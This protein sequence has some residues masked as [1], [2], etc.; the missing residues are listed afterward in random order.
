[1]IRTGLGY[2]SHKFTPNR[3]LILGGVDIEFDKGL[4]AHSNGD[5]VLHALADAIYGAIGLGDIGEHFPNDDP[6]LKDADSSEFVKHAHRI[7][8]VAG[9]SISNCDITV[10]TE[11]P[12][13][14]PYKPA[15]KRSISD[16]LGIDEDAVSI[17]A[18]TNEGMGFVGRGE[19]I[20]VLANVLITK[21]T[22]G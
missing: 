20:A 17:K 4:S 13:L 11:L 10:L 9:W 1:M 7:A 18:K 14:S 22:H 3:P 16:L 12:K 19:G 21:Q 5:V 6:K 2:D 8:T 15:I